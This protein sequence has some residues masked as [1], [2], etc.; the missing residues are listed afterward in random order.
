V[1][2]E[3]GEHSEPP[4][5][6]LHAADYTEAELDRLCDVFSTVPRPAN[7]WSSERPDRRHVSAPANPT[8]RRTRGVD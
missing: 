4:F 8:P 2:S 3:L 7:R 5:L 1:R 6:D